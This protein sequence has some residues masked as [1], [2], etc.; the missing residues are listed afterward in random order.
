MGEHA[1]SDF[2]WKEAQGA[3]IDKSMTTKNLKLAYDVTK[4]A[5]LKALDQAKY[6]VLGNETFGAIVTSP[7]T[8][9]FI[10]HRFWQKASSDEDW[11]TT[12]PYRGNLW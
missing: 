1:Q 7:L 12:T 9:E 3:Q 2:I 10:S 4:D 5:V 8:R 6:E 11:R